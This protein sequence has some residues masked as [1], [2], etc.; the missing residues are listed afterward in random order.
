M[1][2]QAQVDA[3]ALYA[4]RA[5]AC[6][7]QLAIQ[8]LREAMRCEAD[9]PPATE[10]SIKRRWFARLFPAAIGRME[11]RLFSTNAALLRERSAMHISRVLLRCARR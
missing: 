9:A 6:M 8:P 10:P 1:S 5:I 11:R 2:W 3:A 4:G 7:P